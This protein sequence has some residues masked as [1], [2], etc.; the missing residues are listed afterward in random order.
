MDSRD[1]ERS[2]SDD[3]IGHNLSSKQERFISG[4]LKAIVV[5]QG[6]DLLLRSAPFESC[7]EKIIS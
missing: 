3:F 2:K 7:P 6:M 4:L 5:P 1:R